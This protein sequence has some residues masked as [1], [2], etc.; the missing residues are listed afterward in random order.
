MILDLKK[1]F[2]RKS[3]SFGTPK[4]GLF[5]FSALLLLGASPLLAQINYNTANYCSTTGTY[6]TIATTYTPSGMGECGFPTSDV[7]P[8]LFAA[9]NSNSGGG[10]D[11][12]QNGLVCGACAAVSDTSNGKSITV[13]I[14]DG[15]PSCSNAN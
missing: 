3:G 11:D 4:L 14:T 6:S 1:L 13:M 8:N 9:I 15:C 12:Y 7:D 2:Y 5:L 10:G